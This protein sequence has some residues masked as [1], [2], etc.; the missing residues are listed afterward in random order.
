M[1]FISDNLI[2]VLQFGNSLLQCT[3]IHCNYS[4]LDSQGVVNLDGHV[5]ILLNIK[6]GFTPRSCDLSVWKSVLFLVTGPV[7]FYTHND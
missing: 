6:A 2:V 7:L 4:L 3:A 5:L 1:I